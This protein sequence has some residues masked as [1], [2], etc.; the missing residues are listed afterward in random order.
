MW[1]LVLFDL[2]TKT[3]ADRKSYQNFR[4]YLIKDG[5]IMLQF[6][7]YI[8]ICRG[9]ARVKKHINRIEENKTNSGHIRIIKITDK[10]YNDM[11]I[12]LGKKSK[13]EMARNT[14]QM[15]LI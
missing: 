14:K 15:V 5:F 12:V 6:S 10:Q 2:P 7:V 9:D 8:R 3:K 11:S 1:L 4:K 13:N